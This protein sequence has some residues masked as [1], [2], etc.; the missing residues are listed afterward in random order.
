[1][2]ENDSK[3][4]I[5]DGVVYVPATEAV[6]NLG[7]FLRALALQYHTE[8]SLGESGFSGLRV[9]V[10]ERDEDW[11]ESFDQLASRYAQMENHDG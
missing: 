1:M 8:E 2:A 4:V 6:A 11:G 3:T 9:A 10:D 7:D 5:I